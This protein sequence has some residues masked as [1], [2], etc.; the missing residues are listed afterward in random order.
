LA[1][2]VDDMAAGREG[3]RRRLDDPS[4]RRLTRLETSHG[5]ILRCLGQL[6][7]AGAADG[8]IASLDELLRI[9]PEHFAVDEEGPDGVFDEMRA[10]RPGLESRLKSL[11]QDHRDIVEALEALRAVAR[12]SGDDFARISRQRAACIERIRAH[13]RRESHLVMDAYFRDEGGSG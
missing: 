8:I 10:I 5:T 13:E 1:T 11:E 3:T 4:E 7:A 2:E 9:L 12:D 6:E